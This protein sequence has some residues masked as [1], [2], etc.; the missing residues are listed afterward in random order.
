[1]NKVDWLT[2]L[3]SRYN[4]TI[5]IEIRI[6]TFRQEDSEPNRLA[7]WEVENPLKMPKPLCTTDFTKNP[8]KSFVTRYIGSLFTNL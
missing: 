3:M 2:P 6:V 7:T 8:A 4:S 5:G 1:M